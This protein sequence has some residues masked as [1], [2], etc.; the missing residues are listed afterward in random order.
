M[1]MRKRLTVEY[2][3]DGTLKS[4]TI[5]GTWNSTQLLKVLADLRDSAEPQPQWTVKLDQPELFDT[6]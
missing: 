2:H 5:D 6:S 1:D 4:V 3:P